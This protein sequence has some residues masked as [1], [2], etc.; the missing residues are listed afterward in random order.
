MRFFKGEEYLDPIRNQKN[1]SFI[2]H[3]LLKLEV[4]FFYLFDVTLSQSAV[5]YLHIELNREAFYI[6]TLQNKVIHKVSQ[7]FIKFIKLVIHF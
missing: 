1:Y 4:I 3:L 6:F 7:S 5:Y 2:I